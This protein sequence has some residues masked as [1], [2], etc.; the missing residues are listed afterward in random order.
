MLVIFHD[1]HYLKDFILCCA[2]AWEKALQSCESTGKTAPYGRYFLHVAYS[3]LRNRAESLIFLPT[4]SKLFI[5]VP[6]DPIKSRTWA[7]VTAKPTG[8]LPSNGITVDGTLHLTR[9]CP[10]SA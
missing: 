5:P 10:G 6:R 2:L 3:A 7:E 1:R 9:Y 4:Y 8:V